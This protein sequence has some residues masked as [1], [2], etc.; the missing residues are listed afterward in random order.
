MSFFEI[1][2]L[3]W[4]FGI[5]SALM[6][7]VFRKFIFFYIY[8]DHI[9]EDI[10][11]ISFICQY[12]YLQVYVCISMILYQ[13]ANICGNCDPTVCV[14]KATPYTTHY[15]FNWWELCYLNSP[16]VVDIFN[17]NKKLRIKICKCSRFYT[18]LPS[19]FLVYLQSTNIVTGEK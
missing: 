5:I 13:C 6:N 15:K 17:P 3:I 14:S 8:N 2:W 4:T 18:D 19:L 9:S 10:W 1:L 11:Y 16:Q 12:T 7:V